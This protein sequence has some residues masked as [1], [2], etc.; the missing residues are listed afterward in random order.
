M[1]PNVT[2]SD[3]RMMGNIPHAP[4][5]KLSVGNQTLPV[6]KLGPASAR[7]G[8]PWLKTKTIIKK[9][10]KIEEIAHKSK[11]IWMRR[12][13]ISLA[14]DLRSVRTAMSGVVTTTP[15]LKKGGGDV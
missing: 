3:P 14:F 2:I 4:A 11:I 9:I 13:P 5:A 10:A 6:K 12:S 7:N 8:T 1:A 15:L